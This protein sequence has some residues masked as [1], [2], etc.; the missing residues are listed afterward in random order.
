MKMNRLIF[1]THV[2]ITLLIILA[3]NRFS[4]PATTE[5]IDDQICRIRREIWELKCRPRIKE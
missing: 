5:D 4:F 2:M 3:K 1:E